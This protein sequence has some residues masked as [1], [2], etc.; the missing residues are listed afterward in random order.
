MLGELEHSKS[1]RDFGY[2]RHIKVEEVVEAMCK[3]SMGRATG[4]D[5]I[6]VEFWRYVGRAGLEWLTE[7]FNIIFRTKEMPEE[8]RWST[9][10]PIYKNKGDIQNCNNYGGIKL[11]SHT[12]KVWEK[13]VQ[14]RVR[15][16]VSISNNQFGFMWSFY[17]RSYPSYS[18]VG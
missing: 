7:L 18:E 11:L 5:E 2:C 17:H 15:R 14:V 12:M 9:M 6:P 1:H 3:M 13:V 8:W 16:L 4:P 10:I